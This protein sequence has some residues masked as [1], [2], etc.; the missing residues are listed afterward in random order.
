LCFELLGRE[1]SEEDSWRP[2]PF[3]SGKAGKPNFVMYFVV[4][5][6]LGPLRD[7]VWVNG[8]SRFGESMSLSPWLSTTGAMDGHG[9]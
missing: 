3:S 2:F 9:S 6:A 1:G 7:K 8:R 4:L 5:D